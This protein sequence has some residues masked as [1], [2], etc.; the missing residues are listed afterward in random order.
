[1]NLYQFISQKNLDLLNRS[2]KVIALSS[3]L[4]RL[5]PLTLALILI[6]STCITVSN[7]D[8]VAP[9]AFTPGVLYVTFVN[10]Q[11]STLSPGDFLIV[12]FDVAY[13]TI[14]PN[15]GLISHAASGLETATMLLSGNQAKEYPDLSISPV[16]STAGEYVVGIQLPQDLPFGSYTLYLMANSLHLTVQGTSLTGPPANQGYKETDNTSDLSEVQVLANPRALSPAPTATSDVLLLV[17]AIII[18][19]LVAIS[20]IARHRRIRG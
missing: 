20:M 14:D 8:A 1:M 16:A 7:A 10:T 4:P 9:A 17:I 15:L 12:T 6:V 18:L 19:I 13:F 2:T 11:P 3:S 5:K